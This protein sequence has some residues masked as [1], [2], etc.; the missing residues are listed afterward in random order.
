MNTYLTQK[1]IA[2]TILLTTKKTFELI[3]HPNI[4]TYFIALSGLMFGETRRFTFSSG[5]GMKVCAVHPA[6]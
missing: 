6:T 3:F 4:V 5:E 2:Y 1:R